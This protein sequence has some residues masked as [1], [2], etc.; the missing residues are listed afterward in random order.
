MRRS[1]RPPQT[2]RVVRASADRSDRSAREVQVSM[3]SADSVPTGSLVETEV[4]VDQAAVAVFAA[5][6]VRARFVERVADQH[7]LGLEAVGAAFGE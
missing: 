1:W 5:E 3:R 2:Q 4:A 6:P 7:Q